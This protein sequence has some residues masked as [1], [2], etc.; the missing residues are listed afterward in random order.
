MLLDVLRLML[1][2]ILWGG[3]V[4]ILNYTRVAR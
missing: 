2:W 1:G 3:L 4:S